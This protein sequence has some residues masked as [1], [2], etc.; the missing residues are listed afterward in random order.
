MSADE[1]WHIAWVHERLFDLAYERNIDEPRIFQRI[2]LYK[3]AEERL[4]VTLL[5]AE[6]ALA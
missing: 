4:Y 3:A 5:G 1:Q 2:A 6:A